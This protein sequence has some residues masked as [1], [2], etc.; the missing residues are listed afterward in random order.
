MN[1]LLLVRHGG[2]TGNED[3]V[4]YSYHDSALCLT[5]NGIRQAL[6]TGQAL[7][8]L[9]PRW[10]RPGDFTLEVYASEYFRAQQTA[11]IV[12]DQMGLLSL[13]PRIRADLNERDYGTAYDARMDSDATFAGNGSESAINA[14][15]RVRGFLSDITPILYRADVLA[16]SHMGAIRAMTAEL[17]GLTDADMMKLDIRNGGAHLFQRTVGADG[18]AT[19]A[20][21]DLPPHVLPKSAP[22]IKPPED[23]PPPVF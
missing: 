17:L 9:E 5:T 3:N 2:S 14:R 4:F 8:Q 20:L 23:A 18:R 7:A 1:R 19:Y 13:V 10:L 22:P 12:L 11:R 15:L 21:Q 16:F 6:S